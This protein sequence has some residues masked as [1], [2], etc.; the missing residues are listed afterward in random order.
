MDRVEYDPTYD[1][2]TRSVIDFGRNKT[3]WHKLL[4]NG[5][6][7]AKEKRD[8]NRISSGELGTKINRISS[9]FGLNPGQ[10]EALK[11]SCRNRISVIEGPPGTGKSKMA[12]AMNALHSNGIATT[13]LIA[14]TNLAADTLAK[15]SLD[16]GLPVWRC[17][18]EKYISKQYKSLFV[19]LGRN[20]CRR[21]LGEPNL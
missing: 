7:A 10:Q 9:R 11:I 4:L 20:E 19:L 15:Q 16:F 13:A 14:P 2:I 21:S 6:W 3:S 17:G 1:S 5:G 8:A 12:V 18:Q